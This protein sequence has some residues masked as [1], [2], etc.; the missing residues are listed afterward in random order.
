MVSTKTQL[1]KRLGISLSELDQKNEEVVLGLG[2]LLNKK[3]QNVMTTT[4]RLA[5]EATEPGAERSLNLRRFLDR[6]LEILPLNAS[7][8]N[9]ELLLL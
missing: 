5:F 6:Q 8:N 4:P 2:G 3:K 9:E 7:W 1:R